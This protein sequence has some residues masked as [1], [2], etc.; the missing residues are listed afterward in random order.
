MHHTL[1]PLSTQQSLVE[2]AALG[3]MHDHDRAQQQGAGRLKRLPC[4]DSF[5]QARM[6]WHRVCA[7]ASLSSALKLSG[8]YDGHLRFWDGEG[9]TPFLELSGGTSM[10][11]LHT[12]PT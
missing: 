2:V 12:F 8:S 9:L 10:G 4:M 6:G 1:Q 3:P 7:V 11:H 5:Q